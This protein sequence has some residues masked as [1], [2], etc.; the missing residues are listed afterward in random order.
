MSHL[1]P[2][3]AHRRHAARTPAPRSR[4][5]G[6]SLTY[7]DIRLVYW[8]GGNPFHHHQDLNR[9][10]Q[11]WSR[12]ETIIVNEP[13]WTATARHADIVFPTT[14]TLERE[15][16]AWGDAELDAAPMHRVLEPFG[17][18]RDDYAIFTGLAERLGFAERF[19]EGRTAANG[20]S[21]CGT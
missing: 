18:S 11:A 10:R 6:R 13:V 15:D 1:H 5:T 7:P 4:S 9:L 14:T 21:T 19:T 3:G 17:R 20:S 2:G 8:A 16:F 12:P